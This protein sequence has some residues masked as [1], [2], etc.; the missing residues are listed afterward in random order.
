MKKIIGIIFMLW[1][2]DIVAQNVPNGGFEEWE[3]EFVFELTDFWKTSNQ[4]QGTRNASKSND[5]HSGSY[6]M[7]L[8]NSVDSTFGY[9]FMGHVGENGP[10]GGEPYTSDIDSVIGWYKCDMKTGDTAQVLVFKFSSSDTQLMFFPLTGTV[11]TWTRFAF[12]LVSTPQTEVFF[13]VVSSNPFVDY[14]FN[15]NSWIMVDDVGFAKSGGPVPAALSNN[16]FESWDSVWAYEPVGWNSMNFYS[17]INGDT[18]SVQRTRDAYSGDYALKVKTSEVTEDSKV[19]WVY[20][21]N[22]P[23]QFGFS[24]GFEYHAVPTAFSGYYKYLPIGTDTAF[25]GVVGSVYDSIKDTTINAFM[26][27][28]ELLATN[29][30]THFN[31]PIDYDTSVFHINQLN[32]IAVSSR[33]LFDYPDS[34][35]AGSELYL[36]DLWIDSRCAYSDTISLF[37]F[38]DTTITFSAPDKPIFTMDST[39]ASYLW[40]TG[41]TGF[42]IEVKSN[43]ANLTVTVTDSNGCFI[44]DQIIVH[45]NDVTSLNSANENSLLL[46]PNPATQFLNVGA[47]VEGNYSIINQLG[48]IVKYGELRDKIDVKILPEG[49]YYLI[50]ENAQGVHTGK[51]IKR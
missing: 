47:N 20:N 31:F 49:V 5:A 29:Q 27:F 7:R 10:D 12:P 13:G 50:L 46:Y 34:A 4:D 25:I 38:S 24:G 28:K 36:D 39:Y 15:S 16:S 22:A 17:Q 21:G 23:G 45:L 33:K 42:S 19:G 43:P 8:D 9:F 40:S 35:I 26:M 44:T 1:T 3:N 37:D 18:M 30:Y 48:A 41:D 11:S 6:S 32:V 51:F 2:T 14:G